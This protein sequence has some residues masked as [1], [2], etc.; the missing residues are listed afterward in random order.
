M[1]INRATRRVEDQR[2]KEISST[3]MMSR[4]NEKKMIKWMK[5]AS[6]IFQKISI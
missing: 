4:R 1:K 3:L 5:I 6:T 2:Q